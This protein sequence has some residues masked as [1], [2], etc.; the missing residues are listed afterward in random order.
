M[1][2]HTPYAHTHISVW[3][4]VH[5]HRSHTGISCQICGRNMVGLWAFRIHNM[6]DL[7]SFYFLGCDRVE[8]VSCGY[9]YSCLLVF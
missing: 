6:L 8:V 9:D 5:S 1:Y 2:R 3:G 4:I 7:L